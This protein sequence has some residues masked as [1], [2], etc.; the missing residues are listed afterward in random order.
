MIRKGRKRKRV[1]MNG[2]WY[3]TRDFDAGSRSY[4]GANG[5]S[6]RYG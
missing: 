5:F 6:K 3:I 1:R 2:Y 4:T